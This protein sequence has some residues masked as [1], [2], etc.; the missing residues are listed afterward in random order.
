M[1]HGGFITIDAVTT[2]RVAMIEMTSNKQGNDVLTATLQYVLIDDQVLDGEGRP[3]QVK[4]FE[5]SFT[6][7]GMFKIV[8]KDLQVSNASTRIYTGRS[9][10]RAV[11]VAKALEKIGVGEQ[12]VKIEQGIQK[13]LTEFLGTASPQVEWNF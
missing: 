13:F 11:T 9:N 8:V 10:D 3:K 5:V 1:V 2:L 7:Y 6:G 12:Q 4:T